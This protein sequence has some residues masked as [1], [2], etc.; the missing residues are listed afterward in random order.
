MLNC[1]IPRR[2]VN[3]PPL[4]FYRERLAAG[5][6]TEKTCIA[7]SALFIVS[8][9][10][11]RPVPAHVA[12][13][14]ATFI[15]QYMRIIGIDPGDTHTAIAVLED[16]RIVNTEYCDNDKVLSLLWRRCQKTTVFV[17]EMIA[18]YGMPVGKTIFETCV[19][20]GQIRQVI[21]SL[22]FITRI[23]VKSA[24]CHSAKAKDGNIR[25]ALID[26]YGPAGTKKAPGPTYGIS[27][28]M[29]AA[30][31]V[32]TAYARG[33]KLYEFGKPQS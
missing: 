17:C 1:A 4:A 33:A 16:G 26:A 24:I 25:Q 2:P 19:F 7:I 32:A 28:D 3:L 8:E 5:V 12:G 23:S 29:W 30:L 14:P 15:Y 22:R 18:S 10:T 9:L 13:L 11:L 31:A 27:G 21:P 6:K 20:I